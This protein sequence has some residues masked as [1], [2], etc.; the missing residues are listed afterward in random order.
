MIGDY[1][2]RGNFSSVPRHHTAVASGPPRRAGEWG[3]KDEERDGLKPASTK[4]GESGGKPPHSKK[5]AVCPQ[6]TARHHTAVVSGEWR[7][8]RKRRREALEMRDFVGC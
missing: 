1:Q 6:G 4:R 7:V 8:A 3:E 5:R 2:S